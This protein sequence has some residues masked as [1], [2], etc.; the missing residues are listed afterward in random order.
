MDHVN[1]A[2]P[3][4]IAA[5]DSAKTPS[6]RKGQ[7]FYKSRKYRI[8]LLNSILSLAERQNAYEI[9]YN[10]ICD[11]KKADPMLYN[12]HNEILLISSGSTPIFCCYVEDFIL[13]FSIAE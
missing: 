10:V 8:D 6:I 2:I 9:T 3:D 7:F 1:R 5:F 4:E 13:N 11:L 12:I